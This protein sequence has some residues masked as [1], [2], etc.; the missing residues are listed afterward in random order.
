MEYRKIVYTNKSN[1]PFA[2]SDMCN[3]C[4]QFDVTDTIEDATNGADLCNRLN[5]MGNKLFEHDFKVDRETTFYT[6][7]TS[8]GS[9]GNQHYL[10]IYK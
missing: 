4:T 7:L 5:A 8:I 3:N 9:F 2:L 10:I 6:R 1:I